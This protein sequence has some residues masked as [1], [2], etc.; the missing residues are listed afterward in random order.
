MIREEDT[1]GRDNR[2]LAFPHNGVAM[3]V[4]HVVMVDIVH[5]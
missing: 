3:Q 2:D 1:H 5:S 4:V